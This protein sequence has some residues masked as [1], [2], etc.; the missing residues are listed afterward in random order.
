MGLHKELNQVRV[1]VQ[2][3]VIGL[4]QARS[5]MTPPCKRED[6]R[7]RLDADQKEIQSGAA[8]RNQWCRIS[9]TWTNGLSSEI[10]AC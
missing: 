5:D 9:A 10:Q 1:D 8:T 4:T 7:N 3:A 2:N 6:W